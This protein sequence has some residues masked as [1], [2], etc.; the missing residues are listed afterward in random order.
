MM[1]KQNIG[2]S[3][4]L[5]PRTGFVRYEGDAVTWTEHDLENWNLYFTFLGAG[6]VFFANE[7][8]RTETG[9][10]L[11]LPPKLERRYQVAEAKAGWGFY[12]LHFQPTKRLKK[13]LTWFNR[14]EPQVHSIKD[15]TARNRTTAT[16]EEMFQINLRTPDIKERTDLLDALLECLL[17]RVAS[18]QDHSGMAGSGVDQRIERAIEAFHND[19]GKRHTVDSLSRI[20]GL[21]RSQF[22]L[23]FRA[24]LGRSPQEYM[25]ERRMELSRFYLMTTAASIG[26]IAT[27]IGFEDPFYFCTRFKRRFELSPSAYRRANRKL[28]GD[29]AL[30]TPELLS[31]EEIARKEAR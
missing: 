31:A 16:L 21:S 2:S 10:I 1:V 17:I 20:A 6:E 28:G 26:E 23:L 15:P 24:G 7:K 22:C 4:P 9:E 8:I 30:W 25:E 18:T 11:I 19:F 27:N 14:K 5:F 29:V 12:F 13:V 3:Y